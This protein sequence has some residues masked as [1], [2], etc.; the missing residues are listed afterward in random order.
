M[1]NKLTPV[2]DLTYAEATR[3]LDDIIRNMQSDQCDIDSLTAYTRRATEL[4]AECRRRL[5]RTDKELQE[6]LSNLQ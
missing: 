6:I 1:E 4:I 5:T 3:E 2:Q